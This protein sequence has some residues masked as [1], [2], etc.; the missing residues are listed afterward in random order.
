MKL[1]IIA[2]CLALAAVPG[3]ALAE[4]PSPED[5]PLMTRSG[6]MEAPLVKRSFNQL[7]TDHDGRLSQAET[8]SAALTDS[9]WELDHNRDGFLSRQEYD[10]HPN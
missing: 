8:V 7:D 1:S 5:S 2:L 3:A 9:F 4:R 6:S 10:Y